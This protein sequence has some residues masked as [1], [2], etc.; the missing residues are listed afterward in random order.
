MPQRPR[1]QRPRR[2][3]RRSSRPPMR[4]ATAVPARYGVLPPRNVCWERRRHRPPKAARRTVHVGRRTL[5]KDQEEGGWGMLRGGLLAGFTRGA[6]GGTNRCCCHH[7]RGRR[8]HGCRWCCAGVAREMKRRVTSGLQLLSSYFPRSTPRSGGNR[9]LAN[10]LARVEARA[11]VEA[12]VEMGS[13][14]T[15]AGGVSCWIGLTNGRQNRV[16]RRRGC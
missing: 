2:R 9:R 15:P 5:E 7:R 13:I 10:F 1:R 6:R 3:P 8:C 12:K 14:T 4:H 16:R 11:G